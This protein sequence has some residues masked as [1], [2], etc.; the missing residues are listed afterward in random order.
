[1]GLGGKA[2]AGG[3]MPWQLW[4]AALR[5]ANAHAPSTPHRTAPTR[6]PQGLRFF[7]G[8]LSDARR[9]AL[10]ETALAVQAQGHVQLQALK[11][12]F[13]PPLLPAPGSAAAAAPPPA[14]GA[15]PPALPPTDQRRALGAVHVCEHTECRLPAERFWESSGNGGGGGGK[16]GRQLR[17]TQSAPGA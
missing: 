6:P 15:L 4:E 14:K 8:Y 3:P 11:P 10:D 9:E 17:R 1:M 16:G 7:P 5:R 2:A 13:Q 12:G